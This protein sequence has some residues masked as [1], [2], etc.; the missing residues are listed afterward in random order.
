MDM[1]GCW[2]STFTWNVERTGTMEFIMSSF[3]STHEEIVNVIGNIV[4]Y[5]EH[6]Q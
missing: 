5:S 1:K 6:C 3:E 4:K 2:I